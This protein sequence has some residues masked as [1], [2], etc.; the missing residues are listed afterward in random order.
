VA[1]AMFVAVVAPDL[2]CEAE[3]CEQKKQ[4]QLVDELWLRSGQE[5]QQYP[6][7]AAAAAGDGDI[8]VFSAA[9]GSYGHGKHITYM[10]PEPAHTNSRGRESCVGEEVL[11]CSCGRE[12]REDSERRGEH[13]QHKGQGS[14]AGPF[15]IDD[16]VSV[17]CTD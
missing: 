15:C 8:A 16:T 17:V 12:G 5:K 11:L 2:N 6:A 1:V 14:V 3:K 7:A 13:E 10:R 9:A 4:K